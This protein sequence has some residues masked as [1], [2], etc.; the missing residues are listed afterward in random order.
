MRILCRAGSTLESAG[1]RQSKGR[2]MLVTEAKAKL[3]A[4]KTNCTDPGT[5]KLACP[6]SVRYCSQ[7]LRACT[8]NHIC[9]FQHFSKNI[10]CV[11]H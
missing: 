6:S 7:R 11:M 2:L 1:M 10:N 4:L 9:K 8:N 3:T 5:G